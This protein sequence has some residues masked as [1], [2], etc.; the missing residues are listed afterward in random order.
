MRVEHH[1]GLLLPT[2][3]LTSG[4]HT[5]SV[6]NVIVDTGAAQSLKSVDSVDEIFQRYEPTDELVT[7]GGIGGDAISVR[8]KIDIVQL[9]DF[10]TRDFLVD[11]AS[12]VEHPGINGLL[13][14]DILIAGRY[15]L[16]LRVMQVWRDPE[17]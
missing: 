7:L 9:D 12:M 13:G 4:G 16:D 1:E 10:S 14:M 17:R 6:P 5:I 8:R 3:T 15:V 11:F 2:V